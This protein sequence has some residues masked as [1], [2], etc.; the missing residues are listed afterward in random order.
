MTTIAR[1][2]TAPV[3]IDAR[4]DGSFYVAD[5]RLEHVVRVAA[6]GSRTTLGRGLRTPS[7]VTVDR[8]GTVVYVSEFDGRSVR[9]IDVRTGRM[10]TIVR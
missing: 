7:S 10:S 1:G 2:F 5:A 4:P 8:A 9:R 6:D 3:G